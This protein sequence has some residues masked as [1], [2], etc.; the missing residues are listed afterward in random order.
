VLSQTR[1]VIS[2][3]GPFI[4]YGTPLVE[5]CIRQKT[6]YVDITG[7]YS[8][9]KRIID[10]C[11]DQAKAN[12]VMIVPTCGFDSVP[13]DMG[14]YMLSEY[15]HNTHHLDL[16]TVKMSLTK[17]VGGYSGGTVQSSIEALTDRYLSTQ[18]QMDPYLLATRRGIDKPSLPTF[19]RDFDFGNQWQAFFIMSVVNERVVRRS[20][21]IWTDRGK[22]YGSLFSYKES[23][24]FKFLPALVLTT[25]LY[26]V[27]PL[28][29]LMFKV[30]WIREKAQAALPGSG[31]GPD[32]EQ[33]AKGRFTIEFVG[34]A[35]NEPY[36]EPVRVRGTVQGFRDPGYG[37]TCR[38]V[39]E[40][41]LCIVKNL[42]DLPGKEGG[43]LTPSTAF[44]NVLLERLTMNQGMVFEVKDI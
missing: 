1:V 33:R 39:V 16:S 24:T 43:I 40:S 44:G 11:D 9:I 42:K 41:A 19:K 29:A 30:P 7:E 17:L 36:D 20:W 14:V 12:Q 35:E 38:M 32:A 15:M 34:T 27:V 2:T 26:T 13:S 3:V 10:T 18:D 37:D 23:M 25:L 28:A 6:H 4:K 31:A 8:W 21:S 22:S 5:A